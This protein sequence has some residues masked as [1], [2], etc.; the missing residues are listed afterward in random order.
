MK[1]Y[2]F[3]II[4]VFVL[5]AG[6]VSGLAQGDPFSQLDY[7]IEELGNCESKEACEVYCQESKN[8]EACLDFAEVHNLL[9]KEEIEPARKMLVLGE[10]DGPGG[11]QG[12]EECAVYCDE[13]DHMKECILFAEQHDLIPQEELE[14]ARKVIQAMESG[15]IPPKCQGKAECDIYCSKPENMEECFKFGKEAGLIPPEDLKEAEMVLLAIEQG[16]NPPACHGK[17]ECDVYCSSPENMKECIEFGLAA[18]F[19]PLNEVEEVKKTLEALKKGVIPPNCQGKEECDVYCQQEEHFDECINFA[20]AAGFM[21]LEEINMARRTGGRGPGGCRGDECDEYCENPDHREECLKFA[22]EF[23]LMSEEEAEQARRMLE[24]GTIG[25][26]GKCQSEEECEAYCQK[27]ENAMECI[28][29]GVKMGDIAPEEAEQILR[30]METMKMRAGPGGCQ[31]KEECATYCEDPA[32]L[33]ECLAFSAQSGEVSPEEV[34]QILEEM[35]RMKMMDSPLMPDPITGKMLGPMPDYLMEPPPPGS[36]LEI[37]TERFK[38]LVPELLKEPFQEPYPEFIPEYPSDEYPVNKDFFP[39]GQE[40]QP[41]FM[42]EPY[43][44]ELYEPKL[45][46]PEPYK[47]DIQGF[48]PENLDNLMDIPKEIAPEPYPDLFLELPEKDP[49]ELYLFPTGD[50]DSSKDPPESPLDSLQSLLFQTQQFLA[51][52]LDAFGF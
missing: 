47:E 11:C 43:K 15:L 21:S 16:V 44:P 29:F 22:L 26:P 4:A 20:E 10:T 41:D 12:K 9:L 13:I 18:G 51:N 48:F 45:Y 34:Q 17:E 37:S 38:E 2:L 7:P 33:E 39:E 1:Y 23:G 6:V 3:L 35:G 36:T 27:P 5:L 14:E 49:S 40:G 46:E 24:M 25:G 30:D 28:E 32:H 31:S 50:P 52:I 42:Q 19:I 8:M